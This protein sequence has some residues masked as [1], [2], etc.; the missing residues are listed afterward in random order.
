M[1][2]KQTVQFVITRHYPTLIT[3]KILFFTRVLFVADMN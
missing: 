3:I 2:K 1:E